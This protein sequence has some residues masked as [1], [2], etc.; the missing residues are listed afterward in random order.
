MSSPAGLDLRVHCAIDDVA[1]SHTARPCETRGPLPT[2]T[3]LLRLH[4]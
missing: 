4:R 3:N 1:L 2:R